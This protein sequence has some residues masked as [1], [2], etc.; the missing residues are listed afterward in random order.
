MGQINE[1]LNLAQIYLDCG[2]ASSALCVLR[3]G[4]DLQTQSKLKSH[5]VDFEILLSHCEIQMGKPRNA[6]KRLNKLLQDSIINSEKYHMILY[7]LNK[8]SRENNQSQ[9]LSN[10]SMNYSNSLQT[11]IIL[12]MLDM[13][14]NN[15]ELKSQ[16]ILYS[17]K[18]IETHQIPAPEK[19]EL[20]WMIFKGL[21]ILKSKKYKE[22]YLENTA[23]T[24]KIA[25]SLTESM[26]ENFIAK[27]KIDLNMI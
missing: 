13:K 14:I 6:E 10:Q 25:N 3:T 12:Q 9:I 8:I 4:L 16:D 23:L 22:V 2:D 7:L 11:F 18:F 27:Y 24:Y 1:C 17:I 20:K 26:R 5:E 19:L 21:K 15:L